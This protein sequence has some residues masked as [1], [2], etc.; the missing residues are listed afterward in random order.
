MFHHKYNRST[1]AVNFT[2]LSKIDFTRK[3]VVGTFQMY[4]RYGN[5]FKYFPFR[6]AICVCQAIEKNLLGLGTQNCG[7]L[8]CPVKKNVRQTICNWLPD[9]SR[10]PPFLPDGK[11]VGKINITYYD[12]VFIQ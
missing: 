7:K 1:R 4:K 10:L 11:Y 2:L 8:G 6:F 12:S 3:N 5:E 9:Y